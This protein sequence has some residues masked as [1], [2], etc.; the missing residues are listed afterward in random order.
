MHMRYD[1]ST[2]GYSLVFENSRF[3]NWTEVNI[4]EI[5]EFF[6]SLCLLWSH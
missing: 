3:R 2:I 6:A 1:L 5:L 4:Q